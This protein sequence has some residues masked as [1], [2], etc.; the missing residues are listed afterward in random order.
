MGSSRHANY[1]TFICTRSSSGYSAPRQE[2][3]LGHYPNDVTF[4]PYGFRKPTLNLRESALSH[5]LHL[6]DGY[7]AV[8]VHRCLDGIVAQEI[9]RP[10]TTKPVALEVSSDGVT[11]DVRVDVSEPG[12][13]ILDLGQLAGGLGDVVD[14]AQ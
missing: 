13:R 9:L 2:I 6:V 5:L 11:E 4:W 14:L 12:I 1:P 7:D 10:L 3:K 8:D